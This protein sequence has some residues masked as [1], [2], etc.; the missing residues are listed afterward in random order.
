MSGK[1][2]AKRSQITEGWTPGP[3]E[4]E[5]A[6]GLGVD[7]ETQAEAFR[8]FHLA[9]GSLMADWSAAWR[10]WCRNEV[11]FGR[12]PGQRIL[13]LMAVA[14]RSDPADDYGAKGWAASL[15]DARPGT[16]GDGSVV[17]CLRGYD[18]A[19]TARDVCAAAGLPPSWRGNLGMIGDWLRAGLDPD[20]IVEAVRSARP[21]RTPGIW[22]YYDARVRQMAAQAA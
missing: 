4:R 3:R 19:A 7:H 14:T 16:M 8:D 17:I 20:A 10:T 1:V 15:Q 6:E 9:R 22:Q 21:P 11:K 5:F 18:A 2:A 13:P 12:A